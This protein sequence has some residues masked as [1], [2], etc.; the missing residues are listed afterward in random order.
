MKQTDAVAKLSAI[1]HDGRLAI[2][3]RL[4][5]A[6]RDGL[7]P[8]MLA[9]KL[10]M[11]ASTLSANLAILSH[12]GLV[13]SERTGRSILYVADLGAMG[14]L[15]TY[16]IDDCCNGRP[17]ICEQLPGVATARGARRCP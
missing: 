14:G 10:H 2:L 1:A 11:P 13:T 17:E 8:G 5:R 6:G 15:V 12:A 3:R 7:T 16:L 4:I 9:Q